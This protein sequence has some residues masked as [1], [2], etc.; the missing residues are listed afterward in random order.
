M[1]KYNLGFISDTDIETCVQKVVETYTKGMN[2][3]FAKFNKN[4]VDPIKL[5]FDSKVYGQ[6]DTQLI[7]AEIIRQRDKTNT[8]AIG[9][10]HQKIFAYV[11]NGW[12]VPTQGFDVANDTQKIYVEIKN[13]HNTMNANSSQKTYINMQNKLSQD[14]K[15]KCFLVEVIAKKS[16]DIPWQIT[17]DG[18]ESSNENIRRVSIDRFYEIATGDKNAFYKLCKELPNI[19]DTVIS[20]SQHQN[21]NSAKVITELQSIDS[22]ILKALYLKA[23]K[24]Y[25]GF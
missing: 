20:K 12:Y 1:G 13:K 2:I 25:N 14:V 8:N 17:V 21:L 23:F 3:D 10:F 24:T 16:Q 19:L 6:S 15:A 5:T 18:E 4:I 22:N 11:G 9:H 7:Q